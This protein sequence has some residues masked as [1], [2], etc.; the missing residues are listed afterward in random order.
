MLAGE[1]RRLPTP[2]LV[3]PAAVEEVEDADLTSL[4]GEGTAAPDPGRCP[5]DAAESD[6]DD[7][8]EGG[9]AA[10]LVLPLSAAVEQTLECWWRSSTVTPT[11]SPQRR[12]SMT[13]SGG[14]SWTI[15]QSLLAL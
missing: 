3:P 14:H 9:T 8:S 11:V 13:A 5:A 6:D 12:H 7:E 15:L 10:G 1:P 4:W 2:L